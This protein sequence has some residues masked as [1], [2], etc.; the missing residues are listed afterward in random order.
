LKSK[1]LGFY[2]A[3]LHLGGYYTEVNYYTAVLHLGSYYTEVTTQQT[4]KQKK[5]FL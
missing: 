2:T 3:V 4:R 5:S 1:N